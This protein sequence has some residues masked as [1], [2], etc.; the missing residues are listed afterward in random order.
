[1]GF[2]VT[3]SLQIVSWFWQWKNFENRL[4]FG[5]VMRYTKNC[6]IFWPTLYIP[7]KCWAL[8]AAYLRNRGDRSPRRSPRVFST[9]QSMN[10][11]NISISVSHREYDFFREP[12]WANVISIVLLRAKQKHANRES[13]KSAI[14]DD[15]RWWTADAWRWTH[16]TFSSLWSF[17]ICWWLL[18]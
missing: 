2:V 3:V 6:A 8:T 4:I 18:S 5:E 15:R 14:P 11:L 7:A 10:K 1:M 12:F 16:G 13:G 9:L 17:S